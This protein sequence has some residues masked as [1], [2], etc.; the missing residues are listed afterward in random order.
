MTIPDLQKD[1]QEE[2]LATHPDRDPNLLHN[3]E[4]AVEW[5]HAYITAAKRYFE[6]EP[7]Q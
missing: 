5:R 4:V 3:D 6:K 7:I 1:A 2:F